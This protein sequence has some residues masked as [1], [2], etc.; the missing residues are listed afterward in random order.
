M[1]LQSRLADLIAAI[2][3]DIKSINSRILPTRGYFRNHQATA[4]TASYTTNSPAAAAIDVANI[5][6]TITTYGDPVE[7][8]LSFGNLSAGG[9]ARVENV[10]FDLYLDSVFAGR[11]YFTINVVGNAYA[12]VIAWNVAPAAGSHVYEIRW[13]AASGGGANNVALART[14]TYPLDFTIQEQ[15]AQAPIQVMSPQ[16]VTALPVTPYDGQEIYFVVDGAKDIIWHLVYSVTTLKWAFLGGAPLTSVIDAVQTLNLTANYTDLG[17]VGPDVTVPVAGT[18]LVEFGYTGRHS[19]AGQT[20]RASFSRG[21]TAAV[22]ADDT[23]Y[24]AQGASL[25]I[26]VSR[27]RPDVALIAGAVVRMKYKTSSN[28]ATY[29]NRW[30][31]VT[32]QRIG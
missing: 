21:G 19:V 16:R 8:K 29:A 2:G 18:Y 28:T 24:D 4:G 15:T 7:V 11:R 31:K 20:I 1:S 6:G 5:K 13:F 10:G 26:P 3:A 25:F 14:D 23:D 17:T 27:S 30:L 12:G 22:D 9:A 32:P